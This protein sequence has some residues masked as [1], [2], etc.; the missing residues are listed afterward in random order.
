MGRAI[1]Q[2]AKFQRREIMRGMVKLNDLEDMADPPLNGGIETSS[3]APRQ[4]EGTGTKVGAGSELGA[5]S[6]F[7]FGQE[8]INNGLG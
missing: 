5:P 4:H 8:D 2:F 3:S 7:P 1:K 6:N